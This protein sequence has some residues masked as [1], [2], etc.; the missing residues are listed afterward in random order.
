MNKNMTVISRKMDLPQHA[1]QRWRHGDH[2]PIHSLFTDWV[3]T[4]RH[5]KVKTVYPP[6]SLR[7]VGVSIKR[8][9]TEAETVLMHPTRQ[10]FVLVRATFRASYNHRQTNKL[11]RWRTAV[12]R[13]FQN[14]AIAYNRFR[15]WRTTH[16]A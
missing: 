11:L 16:N 2:R 5:A 7:S 9:R 6:V 13:T 8:Q 10:Y 14:K 15:S 3:R 4:D 12:I 1:V